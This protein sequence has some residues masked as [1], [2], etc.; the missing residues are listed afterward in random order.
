M[1]DMQKNET[2]MIQL[3]N[4]LRG[5]QPEPEMVSTNKIKEKIRHDLEEVIMLYLLANMSEENIHLKDFLNG[6]EKNIIINVLK[7]T[8]GSQKMSADI[9]GVK[10]SAFFEKLKKYNITQS[11]RTY[12]KR[13][14]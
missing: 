4:K 10:P 3:F 12:K 14:N 5:R 2:E 11:V 6:F 8:G 13:E 1:W 7:I 9:L